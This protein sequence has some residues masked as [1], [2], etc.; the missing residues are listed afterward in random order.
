MRKAT[1]PVRCNNCGYDSHCSAPLYEHTYIVR[2]F[3]N[4]L[5]KICD[6]CVCERCAGKTFAKA[7]PGKKS[8]GTQ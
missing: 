8:N 7:E 6:A 4:P 1:T 2:T 3:S 5:T